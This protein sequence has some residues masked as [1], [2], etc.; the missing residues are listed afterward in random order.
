MPEKSF[1]SKPTESKI[2]LRR[3]TT[4]DW[5]SL[6]PRLSTNRGADAEVLGLAAKYALMAA[7]GPQVELFRKKNNLT[8]FLSLSVLVPTRKSSP[9]SPKIETDFNM[10][11]SFD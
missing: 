5:V 10:T 9:L 6:P 7:T 4:H 2:V 11:L 8:P 3:E 1:P